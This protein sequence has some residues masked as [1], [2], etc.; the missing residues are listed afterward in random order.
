MIDHEVQKQLAQAASGSDVQ[1]VVV[2]VKPPLSEEA[3]RALSSKRERM[4]LLKEATNEAKRSVVDLVACS[5]AEWQD[6]A[7]TSYGVI[8]GRVDD[9]KAMLSD[10]GVLAGRSDL[11]VMPN[12]EVKLTN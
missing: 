4:A 3:L 10:K 6:M 1:S 11:V 12:F 2:H 9:L 7:G 5:E 8:T